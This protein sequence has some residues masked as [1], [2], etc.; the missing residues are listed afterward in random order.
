MA[1][2]L[3]ISVIRMIAGLN[4]INPLEILDYFAYLSKSI[5]ISKAHTELIAL[6]VLTGDRYAF[7]VL[8]W[9]GLNESG[10]YCQC[11]YPI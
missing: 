4:G 3:L 9:N 7:E 11:G 8:F 10:A 6:T 2:V 1:I 5:V